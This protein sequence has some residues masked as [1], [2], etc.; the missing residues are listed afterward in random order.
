[1]RIERIP[2]GWRVW[3][4]YL[5]SV[6]RPS[7]TRDY[8]TSWAACQRLYPVPNPYDSEGQWQRFTHGDLPDLDDGQLDAE[9]RRLRFVLDWADDSR[10]DSWYGERLA[11]VEG[12]Q[13][14]RRKAAPPLQVVAVERPAPRPATG[15]ERRQAAARARLERGR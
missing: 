1:M 5:N 4:A 6:R 10:L 14:R 2:G 11:A 9:R 12:E 8:M 15:L 3:A 7:P 13:A